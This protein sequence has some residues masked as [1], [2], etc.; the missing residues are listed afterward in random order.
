MSIIDPGFGFRC[1]IFAQ[2]A[3]SNAIITLKRILLPLFKIQ[4]S[5]WI[6]KNPIPS[7]SDKALKT[8]DAIH[9][10]WLPIKFDEIESLFDPAELILNF[11]ERGKVLYLPPLEK[12][13][14]FV[15]A[16]SL[17]CTLNENQSIA[18][19]R[20]MLVCLDEDHE[21]PYGI[22]FRMETPESMNQNGNEDDNQGIHD[23]HHVQL[24]RT[25]GQ[26]GLDNSLPIDCPCWLPVSQPSFP[27]P[28]K[29]PVMLL[30]CLILTLYGK[31]YYYQFLRDH[32]IGGI[33]EYK[34]ALKSW[35]D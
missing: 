24:I 15:P 34:T 29:C 6:R 8:F 12:N 27:L 35:I 2:H 31:Q 14:N 23:F 9:E 13:A 32:E 19:L 10:K 7:R 17:S 1:D 28:A 25:F 20:V 5:A 21:K 22:G 3:M 11:P 4:E 33:E 26:V 18:K 30:L 16:L